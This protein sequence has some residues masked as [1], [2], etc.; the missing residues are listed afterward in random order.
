VETDS[1]IQRCQYLKIYLVQYI[2]DM[3][4]AEAVATGGNGPSRDSLK[5][6]I[7]ETHTNFTESAPMNDSEGTSELASAVSSNRICG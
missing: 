6:S 2:I 4:S 5:R 1:G 7:T 3:P